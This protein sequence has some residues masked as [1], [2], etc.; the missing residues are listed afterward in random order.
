[1]TE[2][3]HPFGDGATPKAP[4][5]ADPSVEGPING[6]ER[7]CDNPACAAGHHHSDADTRRLWWALIVIAGF[8]VVEV[9]GGL[10]SG[11]LA[12][13]ADAGHMV[14][15]GMALALA[16]WARVLAKKPASSS[17]PYGRS[18]AQVLAAFVNGLALFVLIGI[19]L[20]ES[21]ERFTS[22]VPIAT[23]TMLAVAALGLVAN[24]VAFAIL[25]AGD[26]DDINVRGAL[27][28]V[29]GDLL[30]S[31]AAI[32]SALVIMGTG[33]LAADPLVTIIVCL[34]IAR[35]AYALT[36]DA[37]RVL[38]QAAPRGLDLGDLEAAVRADVPGI[39][40]VHDVKVWMLTPQD[41]QLTM[42]ATAVPG[43]DCNETLRA[44]K[45]LL[46]ERFGITAS[47]IQ[48][49]EGAAGTFAHAACPDQPAVAVL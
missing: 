27:L 12:L 49:E 1:M 8:A 45:A 28:H 38:L 3:L 40:D 42:H 43:A 24:I 34:L 21:F 25:H 20:R 48:L 5:K 30:G 15:D 36:K 37:G 6:A 23:G 9:I 41:V 14:T 11:S 29:I 18:R 4:R 39:A 17:L 19:L 2:L 32:V 47:I 16:L 33:W 35:S 46:K 10:I 7:P 22:P 13:L 26:R 31:V 44:T